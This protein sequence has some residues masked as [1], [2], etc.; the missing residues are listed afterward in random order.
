M[1]S[2]HEHGD[3]ESSLDVLSYKHLAYI[4]DAFIYYFRE[5]VFNQ[6]K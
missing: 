6:S 5:N 2:I 4:L 3:Q 1:R